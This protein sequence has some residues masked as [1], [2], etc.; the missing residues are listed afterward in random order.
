M[1]IRFKVSVYKSGPKFCVPRNVRDD[2]RIGDGDSVHLIIRTP[3]GREIFRGRK[4]LRS[5]PEI[6][7]TDVAKVLTPGAAIVVEASDPIITA[8]R[9]PSEV[10]AR[11]L[12]EGE[13]I[14][15]WVNRFERNR[16]ARDLCIRKFGAVCQVCGFDFGKCYG[17]LGK[18]FI[19]VHHLTPVSKVAKEY[20]IDPIKDLR[21]VCPNCHEMLH[22]GPNPPVSIEELRAIVEQQRSELGLS[23]RLRDNKA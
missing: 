9:T 1:A 8:Y 2:L 3:A 7:G 16:K 11:E 21:P 18:G 14:S 19:Q 20:K 6:Y 10:C 13:R 5:G 17:K 4:T 12:T 23:E 22:S 15:S